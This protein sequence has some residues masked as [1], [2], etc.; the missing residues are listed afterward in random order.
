M[1]THRTDRD[2]E[3]RPVLLVVDD[4]ELM[5]RLLA[6]RL[7]TL[8]FD[9]ACFDDPRIM[10][11]ALDDLSPAGIFTDLQMPVL[12]GIGV[13]AAAREAG[14][15]GFIALVTAESDTERIGDA[16]A[17]GAD[18]VLF[19]PVGG[20]ELAVVV[21]RIAAG[22]D[23]GDRAVGLRLALARVE[24]GA[25][26]LDAEGRT[27]F[28]NRAA[29]RVFGV[30]EPGAFEEAFERCCP[31]ALVRS[32][33][34]GRSAVTYHD[35]RTPEKGARLLVGIEAHQLSGG[36][37]A[38]HL[39][40]LH[41]FSRWRRVDDIHSRFATSLSHRMR[42]PL[43][44]ARN[45]MRML[46]DGEAELPCEQR[47]RLLDIGWR[48]IERLVEN[49]DELQ[50]L[51]M[52]ESNETQ[53]VRTLA[54]LDALVK[55]RLESLEQSGTIRGFHMRSPCVTAFVGR[56]R[57]GEFIGAAVESIARWAGEMPFVDCT[58]SIRENFHEAGGIER[59][60]KLVIRPRLRG[61]DDRPTLGEFL[62]CDEA[63]RGLVLARL[64]AGLD[65]DLDLDAGGAINL[66]LPLHPPFDRE[67]DL[68]QPM[69]MMSERAELSGGAFHLVSLQLV[70]AVDD[71]VRFA[72]LVETSLC[73]EIG[74]DLAV[75]R[76]QEPLG[77]S[78]FFAGEEAGDIEERMRRVRDRFE[79]A[80]RRSG[81]EIHPTIRW[82][83]R[84][85]REARGERACPILDIPAI[86]TV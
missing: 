51:Y 73:R 71:A 23:R 6:R 83:I 63:H 34:A 13:I 19:K 85:S 59:R 39:L 20:R 31:R 67:K 60:I 76:A 33:A 4:D 62:S 54:R 35:V 86:E 27:L 53:T 26:L 38:A 45:A 9:V 18:S 78:I 69:N 50:K 84:F 28:S 43:T 1:A 3:T 11:D 56:G 64:A 65:G 16:V 15:G 2:R 36:G 30:S 37:A 40:L 8:G 29:H 75:S 55:R 81:E 82:E 5:R 68:V 7:E 10:L 41:D 66:L 22:G 46:G 79:T 57:L 47:E 48:N 17:A 24:Q 52:I 44:A 42:T 14:Y 21:A 58:A 74:D 12:D 32:S 25:V 80:C 49:L 72:R 70:G 61:G 77:Y